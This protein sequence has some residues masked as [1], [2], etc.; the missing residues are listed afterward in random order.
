MAGMSH[1]LPAGW[2]CVAGGQHGGP[3]GRADSDQGVLGDRVTLSP[4][5]S[6][7]SSS[8]MAVHD[9]LGWGHPPS[10]GGATAPSFFPSWLPWNAD[11]PWLG[12]SLDPRF[13]GMN[14]PLA[15]QGVARAFP[16]RAFGCAGAHFLLF[17][18]SNRFRCGAGLRQEHRLHPQG[19]GTLRGLAEAAGAQ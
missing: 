19:W 2:C 9:L 6:S 14:T 12:E 8:G 7:P 10:E 4:C 16:G 17:F 11:S 13:W 5:P 3:R 1:R 18:S 15:A